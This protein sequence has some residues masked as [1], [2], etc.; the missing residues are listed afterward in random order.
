ME[1]GRDGLKSILT[2]LKGLDPDETV[3]EAAGSLEAILDKLSQNTLRET[4]GNCGRGITSE[5]DGENWLHDDDS[6]SRGCRA[7]SYV[8]GQGWSNRDMDRRKVARPARGW[9]D[10]VNQ[11]AS[12]T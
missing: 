8:E 10:R 6:H 3:G 4:C 2:Y 9:R 12:L 7:A 5:D 1:T 11:S